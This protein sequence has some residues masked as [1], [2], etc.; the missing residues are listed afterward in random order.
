[1]KGI[2]GMN[3]IKLEK[4]VRL[5]KRVHGV[6]GLQKSN[7]KKSES[8]SL[9]GDRFTIT[10]EY[11]QKIL[12]DKLKEQNQR[13]FMLGEQNDINFYNKYQRYKFLFGEEISKKDVRTN[14]EVINKLFTCTDIRQFGNRRI[15]G[16]IEGANIIGTNDN[17]FEDTK[18]IFKD[19]EDY[20]DEVHI[21]ID[22]AI[23]PNNY[24]DYSKAISNCVYSQKDYDL[25]KK[26][27]IDIL[28]EGSNL[29][30]F[31]YLIFI[32]MKDKE[33]VSM[34][35]LNRYL[36]YHR[37]NNSNKISL[38]IDILLKYIANFKNI[39]CVDI[40][41]KPTVIDIVGDI[42]LMSKDLINIIAI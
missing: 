35:N 13:L 31:E 41:Y 36:S 3:Q 39:S 21:P 37:E 27:C 4:A 29:F 38:N 9:S 30:N 6:L 42:S 7:V 22:F 26:T 28:R 10:G 32:E 5:E 20:L 12:I 19:G 14:C 17:C 25:Y 34:A 1:M 15:G 18:V 40:Y 16:D 8:M 11:V 33:L 23:A 24:N 2:E